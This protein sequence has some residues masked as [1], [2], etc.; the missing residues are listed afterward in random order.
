MAGKRKNEKKRGNTLW[1]RAALWTAALMVAAYGVIILSSLIM[2]AVGEFARFRPRE[3]GPEMME[4][5]APFLGI[6]LDVADYFL[7]RLALSLLNVLLA[8]YL[9]YVH[10]KD[11][12]LLRSGFTLGII[13]FLFSFLMYALSTL[14]LQYRFLG[15][16]PPVFSFVPMLF[17]AIGLLIFAKLSND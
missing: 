6:S 4:Q 2:P 5:P 7:L 11:Y 16:M 3:F 13:A 1:M 10:V 8:M 17:S 12:L 15:P 9:I 14:P